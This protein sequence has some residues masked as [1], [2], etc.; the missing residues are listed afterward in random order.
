MKCCILDCK[1]FQRRKSPSSPGIDACLG[2]S[3]TSSSSSSPCGK[4]EGVPGQTKL[5]GCVEDTRCLQ[6]RAAYIGVG[7]AHSGSL[8]P[9][10]SRF[11]SPTGLL[12]MIN[13]IHVGPD[14]M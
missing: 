2:K 9:I 5:T 10:S 11:S 8:D 7:L 4:T 6:S 14:E 1:E 3:H 12:K 13:W